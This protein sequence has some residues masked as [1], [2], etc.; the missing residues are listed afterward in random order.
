MALDFSVPGTWFY[1]VDDVLVK[2]VSDGKAVS[3][4]VVETGRPFPPA[5]AIVEGHEV[6]A[7]EADRLRLG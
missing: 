2:L 1:M 5:K 6:S 3:G 7:A 4:S